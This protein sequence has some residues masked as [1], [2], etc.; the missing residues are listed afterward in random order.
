LDAILENLENATI[1]EW[2]IFFKRKGK[3]LYGDATR[4]TFNLLIKDANPLHG[5]LSKG[6]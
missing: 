6:I 2:R 4:R 5:L 1:K 3:K